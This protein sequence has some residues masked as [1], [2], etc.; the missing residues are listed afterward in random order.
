MLL[1]QQNRLKLNKQQENAIDTVAHQAANSERL[2]RNYNF[3]QLSETVPRLINMMQPGSYIRPHC[4]N[5]FE[6]F[7]VLQGK[8]GLLLFNSLNSKKAPIPL[9]M[10]KTF[11]LI[12]LKKEQPQPNSN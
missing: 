5:G 11:S 10:T 6:F 4:H 9:A 1:T 7:L 3:H 12:S 2:R 8:M